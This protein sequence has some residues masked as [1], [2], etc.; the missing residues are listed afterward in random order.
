MG[1]DPKRATL[2]IGT[3]IQ[4]IYGELALSVPDLRSREPELLRW[5]TLI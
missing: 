2:A 1:G 4:I 5:L 3:M